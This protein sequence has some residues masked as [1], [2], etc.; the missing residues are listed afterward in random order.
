MNYFSI[1]GYNKTKISRIK[2]FL[3]IM[4]V[5]ILLL[6][7]STG[8][9]LA[10]NA[11]SQ[12]ARVTIRRQ[13]APLESV[14]NEIEKQT[15]YLFLYNGD[16][17]DVSR[18]VSVN[19]KETP[20]SAVLTDLFAGMPVRFVMEG[21]HIILTRSGNNEAAAAL[22]AVAADQHDFATSGKVRERNDAVARLMRQQGVRV[23]GTVVDQN[24]E[25]IIGA[26]VI[27][28]GT[29]NG[30]VT[31]LD[32][33]FALTVQENAILQISYVGYISQEISVLSGGGG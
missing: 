1:T 32:G 16:D 33:K 2:R 8:L 30:I 15:D 21:S 9:M 28:K 26:N 18:T 31:D 6:F 22:I 10:E 29:T 3:S 19:A 25:P 11:Y 5:A 27:E 24:G 4:R 23:T 12:K 13:K 7:L 14:L 20:V 17:V